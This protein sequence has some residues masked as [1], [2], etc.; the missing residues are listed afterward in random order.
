MLLVR[1][2]TSRGNSCTAGY[3][4]LIEY[5]RAYQLQK[6]LARSRIDGEIG[7]RLLLLEHPPTVTMGRFGR[8]E[9]VVASPARLAR[10]G[11]S[12]VFSDRGGD[13][14]Y[15]GPGQLVGYP[16]IDLRRR[17]RDVRQYIHDLEEVVIGVLADF[18][19]SAARDSTHPGVWVNSEGIAAIGLSIRRWVSMHG[20]ALNVSLDL[21][22]FSLIN[23]CGLSGRRATS[24]SRQLGREVPV[25]AVIER[26]LAHFGR[27]FNV[28]L[29]RSDTL[30]AAASPEGLRG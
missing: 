27:V 29:E 28:S 10:E 12:L 23:P 14:T 19:I 13:V 18:G 8:M 5:R 20:F 17:D 4:G 25:T 9:N 24:I 26:L 22:P 11:I 7:D 30:V 6:R 1:R 15:H 16:I 21:S 2:Y 3:L